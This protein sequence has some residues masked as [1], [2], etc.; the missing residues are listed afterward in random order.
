MILVW[1]LIGMMLGM[2]IR[3]ILL[4]FMYGWGYEEKLR[5]YDKE[6]VKK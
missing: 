6:R 1:I 3:E 4:I 2:G 5:I